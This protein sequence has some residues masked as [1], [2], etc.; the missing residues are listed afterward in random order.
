MAVNLGYT[1]VNVTGIILLLLLLIY[2]FNTYR[3]N[4]EIKSEIGKL[5][6]VTKRLKYGEIEDYCFNRIEDN[7]E[8][9]TV[10]TC[11]FYSKQYLK[12]E[13]GKMDFDNL[14]INELR[15]MP[16]FDV[17]LVDDEYDI[18][19]K[20]YLVDVGGTGEHLF[21]VDKDTKAVKAYGMVN[22]EI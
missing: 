11:Y 15:G 4:K 14:E 2:A 18:S 13:F 22:R 12:E 6:V 1:T 10:E 9:L 16:K 21:I 5:N 7:E 19:A 8:R 3:L 17:M 20:D